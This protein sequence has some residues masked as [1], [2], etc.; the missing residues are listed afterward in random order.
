MVKIIS[1]WHRGY[2]TS[3]PSSMILVISK[4]RDVVCKRHLYSVS[5]SMEINILMWRPLSTI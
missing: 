4:V 2:I 3:G 1:L 5:E